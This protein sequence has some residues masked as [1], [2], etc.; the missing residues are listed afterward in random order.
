MAYYP[1]M[2]AFFTKGAGLYVGIHDSEARIKSMHFGKEHDFKVRAPVENAGR[3][4]LAAGSVRF[5]TTIAAIGNDWWEAARRYRAWALTTKWASKGRILDR[6]DYPRRMAEIP[7]W[8]N[9]H[10]GPDYV[11]NVLVRAKK[12]FPDTPSGVHWHAWQHSN[13]VVV[14]ECEDPDC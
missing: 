13:G 8:F 12:V 10:G 4:G 3:A 1:M 14:S 7:L 9:I 6:S 5:E 11:S 2:M